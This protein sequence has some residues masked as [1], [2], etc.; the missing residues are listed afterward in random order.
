VRLLFA[1]TPV[2]A[3]PSL[4]ALIASPRHE[5][6]GVLTRPDAKAGRG[7]TLHASPIKE[8]ALEH[9]IPVLT[10]KTLRDEAALDAIREL[11]PDCAPVV[12]YG[13]LIPKSALTIPTI[14]WVNLHF[15]LLPAWRGAA[16]V[17]HAIWHG[18]DIS[19]ASTFLIEEG[20][21]TGPVFGVLTEVIDPRDTAGDLLDRL[22]EA[23]AQ[24][25]TGTLDAIEDGTVRAEPQHDDGISLAPK[26][27]VEQAEIDW[28]QPAIA[29]D[30]QIRACTPAPGAWTTFR[31]ERIKIG[32][33]VPA[34]QGGLPAGRIAGTTVGAGVGTLTLGTVQPAGKA[35]MAADAWARGARITAGERFE[36]AA[37][38][39]VTRG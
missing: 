29:I 7:R 38:T 17:Q 13:N 1:G 39:E 24:L 2:A 14:G 10:P 15:S 30:R 34:D 5:V 9:D 23:G 37:A 19:G 22:A 20:L 33:A 21:D 18:D 35:P 36:A 3:V 4:R 28:N 11:E 32:P 16:P 31:G 26:I 12:A 25:L 8:V 27:T 6:V